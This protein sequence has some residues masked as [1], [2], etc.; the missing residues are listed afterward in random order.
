M[1]GRRIHSRCLVQRKAPFEFA[2]MSPSCRMRTAAACG[3][4]RRPRPSGG[5]IDAFADQQRW[6]A[7]AAGDG[8]LG[9]PCAENGPLRHRLRLTVLGVSPAAR[10]GRRREERWRPV[11]P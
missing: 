3:V 9:E 11:P 5:G 10:S 1:S 7:G 6:R 8:E 4:Q 2:V